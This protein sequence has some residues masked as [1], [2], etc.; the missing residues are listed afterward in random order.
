LA[1][2]STFFEPRVTEEFMG[3]TGGVQGTG[4]AILRDFWGAKVEIII[5]DPIYFLQFP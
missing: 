5:E 2:K 1:L 3:E 4:D